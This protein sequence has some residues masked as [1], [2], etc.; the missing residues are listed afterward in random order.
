MTY[1]DAA[2]FSGAMAAL[3]MAT[4]LT[5]LSL[6]FLSAPYGKHYRPGWGPAIPAALAWPVME[7]PTLWLPLLLLPSGRHRRQPLALL[8]LALFLLHYL[9]RTLLYPLSLPPA[10][11]AAKPFPL[12]IAAL[13]FLFNLLN[14]YLQT[15][16][17]SHYATYRSFPSSSTLMLLRIIIGV[18]LFFVGMG[19]NVRSDRELVRLKRQGGGG[20][21]VP[22]GGMFEWVSCPNYLG[23]VVEWFG[24][25]VVTWSWPAFAFFFYTCA[26]LVPRARAHHRWYLE[27]FPDDYPRSRKAIFPFLY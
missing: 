5:F 8:P 16:H 13:A 23:E 11:A 18:V 24:W 21:K 3:A 17:L 1:D 27:K 2:I 4:P 20:Y 15:R 7:S 19:V 12:S 22:R 9:H 26:N 10:G 6:Q 14:S 25:A